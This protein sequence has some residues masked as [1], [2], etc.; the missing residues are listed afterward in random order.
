MQ[1]PKCSYEPTLSEVQASPDD[2]TKCGVNYQSHAQLR[3]REL[4]ERRAR[5]H[6]LSALA[7]EVRDVAASYPGAQAVVVVDVNMSFG[8]MV[9]FMVKWAIATVPAAIILIILFWGL[10]SFLSF[11]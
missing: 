2:C 11:L 4:A 8:A 1:C 9:R 5:K 10:T 3:D 7:P 6:E